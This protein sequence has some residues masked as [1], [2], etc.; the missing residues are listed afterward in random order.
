MRGEQRGQ[1]DEAVCATTV[2][3]ANAAISDSKSI[4]DARWRGWMVLC[5]SGLSGLA[6]GYCYACWQWA[7]EQAQV[8]AGIV[9]YP[10]G[11]PVAIADARL[12]SVI[13][14]TCAL[15]LSSGLREASL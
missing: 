13:P 14:Q 1:Q 8:F 11:A 12:W 7:V 5:L 6:L 15:L 10:A 9:A 2:V 3:P 4:V